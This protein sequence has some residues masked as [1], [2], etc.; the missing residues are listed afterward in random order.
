MSG[1]PTPLIPIAEARRRVLATVTP[2][3]GE[4]VPI[5]GALGRVLAEDLAATGDVPPFPSSAMDGYA[6][7]HGAAGAELRLVGEARAGAPSERSLNPG[8]A[9]RIS[10]GAAVPE[11][12]TAV[13]RQEDVEDRGDTILL[14]AAV[15]PGE[16]VRPR[17]EVMRAG[18][19]VL[20]KGTTLRAAELGTAVAAGAG[21][22]IVAR[23]PRLE[24][25]CTGDELREPGEPL[26][27]GEIHNSNGPMLSAL[28]EGAGAQ[29]APPGRLPDDPGATEAGLEAALARSDV[30]VVCGGVSV[31]PHD[32]VKPALA[33]LGVR[34]IFWGV[35]LQ[36]GK[37]T[38]FGARESK[39]VFGLPGNPV[40]AFVT[41]ALFVRYALAALQGSEASEL[42]DEGLLG[43]A[44][45]RSHEREQ[46]LRVRLE[47]RDGR[48]F[49]VPNGPQG[50]HVLTSLIGA[51]ALALIPAGEGELE[52]G[53]PVALE[54][55]PR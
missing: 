51:D 9:I 34:E 6:V 3:E 21:E 32:H 49:A 30:V 40:S 54:S 43:V 23:S 19:I 27:A 38:W 29:T 53:T 5:S 41:F 39:L 33:K 24:V 25:L 17:G 13:I 28:A 18:T 22:L 16:N 10:T 14:G 2:L 50:S 7:Q 8:E 52:P 26:A 55:L 42:H 12:A 45:R 1:V 48:T 35:A 20:S 31:G 36:P 47:R 46:A 11:A 4:R 37:P 15:E 44:V